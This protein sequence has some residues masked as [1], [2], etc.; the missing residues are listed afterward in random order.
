VPRADGTIQTVVVW[1]DTHED[2]DAV[3]DALAKKYMDADSYPFRKDG[4]QR[5]TFRLT[6]ETVVHKGA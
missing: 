3:I 4:E 6:P 2:G 1:A 5:V